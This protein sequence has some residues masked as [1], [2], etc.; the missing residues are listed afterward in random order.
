MSEASPHIFMAHNNSIVYYKGS[1]V[2][3]NVQ[4]N[5]HD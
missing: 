2:D 3:S 5:G 1:A 4:L